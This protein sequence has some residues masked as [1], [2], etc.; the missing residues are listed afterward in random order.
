MITVHVSCYVNKLRRLRVSGDGVGIGVL[1]RGASQGRT[2]CTGACTPVP[3]LDD[4]DVYEAGS[5]WRPETLN[6]HQ[7]ITH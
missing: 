3:M 6:H 7:R 4:D 2:Q 1:V 5:G